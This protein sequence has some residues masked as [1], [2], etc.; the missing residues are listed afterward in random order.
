MRWFATHFLSKDVWRPTR[1]SLAGGAAVGLWITSILIPGQM[2][3]AV[4]LCGLLRLNIPIAVL[5]CWLSNPF[6]FGPI[7]WWEISLGNWI[8]QW[9]NLGETM[10]LGWSQLTSIVRESEDIWAFFNEVRP[11][12]TSLYLG[13]VVGG[14]LAGLALYVLMFGLWDAVLLV[15]HRRRMARAKP[16]V[17]SGKIQENEVSEEKASARKSTT[18]NQ[19]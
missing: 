12:A 7:A 10:P 19:V 15:M 18:Q 8:I 17:I 14:F 1:H 16:A 4:I 3:M 2:P 6:T 5:M 11:W 13:G 9:L